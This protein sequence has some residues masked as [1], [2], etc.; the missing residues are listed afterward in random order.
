MSQ[1]KDHEWTDLQLSGSVSPITTVLYGS[2]PTD[3][4][5]QLETHV[6]AA[7]GGNGSN[8]GIEQQR[9]DVVE[10]LAKMFPE[11]C[12]GNVVFDW[13]RQKQ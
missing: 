9:N 13:S 4:M 2:S 12:R 3:L 8:Y 7:S 10:H 6:N 1:R 5:R 11:A